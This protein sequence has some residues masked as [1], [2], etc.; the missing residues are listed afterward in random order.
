MWSGTTQS[1]EAK[2]EEPRRAAIVVLP[3]MPPA[4]R[5]AKGGSSS[6]STVAKRKGPAAPKPRPP[7][8]EEIAAA[9][10]AEAIAAKAEA[11]AAASQAFWSA[12]DAE[13]SSLWVV[14]MAHGVSM[15]WLKVHERGMLVAIDRARARN[16]T[17]LLVDNTPDRLIDTFYTY[18]SAL[19]IEAKQ[20]VLDEATGRRTHAQVMESLRETLV[21]AMRYGSTL[22][23]RL[24]DSAC[25]F[26]HFSSDDSFPLSLFA[27]ETVASLR[28]F[29][30]AGS[31]N[32]WESGHPLAAVLRETGALRRLDPARDLI[33][34]R[35][36]PHSC[37][38]ADS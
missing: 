1:C 4:A 25:D 15:P 26:N 38:A 33:E 21:N 16:K 20:L 29:T 37:L 11:D 18:Q 31:K 35:A 34:F 5:P 19:V 7:T 2:C 27:H 13:P 32:L 36:A 10:V 6:K 9:A 23:I 12:L 28:D 3:G 14:P 17:V 22:Y 8:E 24:A 30:G